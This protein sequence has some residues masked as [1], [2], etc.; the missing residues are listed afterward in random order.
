MAVDVVVVNYHT[1]DL[2]HDFIDSYWKSMFEGCTLTVVEVDP[3]N[4]PKAYHVHNGMHDVLEQYGPIND[5]IEFDSN[6]GYAR[7]CNAGAQHGQNDVI[8]FANADTVLNPEALRQCYEAL[9]LNVQ[10]GVLGP[11]Q[12]DDQ[13]FITAGGIFGTDTNIGQ[14][15]WQEL[16]HGQYS[17]IREDAKSVSGSLYFIKRHVWEQLTNCEYMQR[18]YPHI[19]G[20]FIP[21]PHYYEET[22]CSY[23]ARAHGWK[24]VFFG[25][26]KMIHLWHRASPHGGAADMKVEESKEMMRSFCRLHGITCE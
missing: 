9:D 16:D 23:H 13:G 6:V 1:D 21:T 26:A 17:D 15:G 7:A 24:I 11:R 8:L 12:V 20:A 25:P 19:E 22:C 18:A 14:R 5:L 3:G 10:W 4:F 2:L